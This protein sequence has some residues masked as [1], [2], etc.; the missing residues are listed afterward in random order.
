M[1]KIL[2]QFSVTLNHSKWQTVIILKSTVFLDCN[3]TYIGDST[4]FRRN[5]LTPSSGPK[6]Q[7]SKKPG[8]SGSK[9]TLL[10]D[11]KNRG[12]MFCS[13]TSEYLRHTR[14]YNPENRASHYHRRENHGFKKQCFCLQKQSRQFNVLILFHVSVKIKV[15]LFALWVTSEVKAPFPA[16]RPTLL[17]TE[18]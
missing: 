10:F 3:A 1:N 11:S 16:A 14:H 9:L 15:E 6:S 2:L 17:V 8:D 13:E 18:C 4:T 7:P 5:I 12:D